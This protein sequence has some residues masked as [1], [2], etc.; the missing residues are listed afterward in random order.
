MKIS[1]SDLTS[2]RKWRSTLGLDEKRFYKLLTVFENSYLELFGKSME[3]RQASNPSPNLV[4]TSYESLLFFTLFS[5][6]SGLTYDLLG[7]VTGMEGSSAQR[8]QHLGLKILRNG[9]SKSGVLPK[10]NFSSLKAFKA[11]FEKEGEL[12]LDG[13]EQRSERPS[14]YEEQKERYSGKKKDI[15]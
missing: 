8:N 13:V 3:E 5:L 11:Y 15:Q 12:I 1:V 10:R 6:K 14:D 2:D 7:V 9:L 4:I